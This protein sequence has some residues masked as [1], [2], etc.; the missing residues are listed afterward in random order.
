MLTDAD[1]IRHYLNGHDPSFTA[2]M[3]RRQD[4]VYSLALRL[5]G[6]PETAQDVTQRVFIKVY[7]RLPALRE[8]EGFLGWLLKITRNQ[9]LDE[10]KT[11]HRAIMRP[12]DP[13]RMPEAADE[14][15]R[16]D[17]HA[18]QVSTIRLLEDALQ[19]IPAEQRE[20]V[21]MKELHQLTFPEIASILDLP[22]NT[23]KSRLYYGLKALSKH[24]TLRHEHLS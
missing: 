8:P 14:T 15:L 19:R 12:L 10:L 5:V 3:R 7:E 2:L 22:E 11:K 20:V 23:V 17:S 13:D 21:V 1:L 4:I 18:E 16:A 24:A 6:D 9:C